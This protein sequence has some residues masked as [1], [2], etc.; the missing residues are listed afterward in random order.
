MVIVLPGNIRQHFADF[1]G[2][3]VGADG[4]GMPLSP[5]VRIISRSILLLQLPDIAGPVMGLKNGH[6]IIANLPD[7]DADL[8]ADLLHELIDKE[9]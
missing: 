4:A 9:R 1:L 5:R 8:L 2:Q 6:G 3:H 7:L